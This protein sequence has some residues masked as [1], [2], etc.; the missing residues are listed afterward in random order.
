[1]FRE[2]IFY[3]SYTN[4]VSST[5][6]LYLLEGIS[7]ILLGILIIFMPGLL[8]GLA[9]GFLCLVGALS[10]LLGLRVRRLRR[11]YEQKSEERFLQQHRRR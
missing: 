2:V 10:I 6:W 8:I 7:L 5:W 11:R 9:A 1:M 3:D 4:E